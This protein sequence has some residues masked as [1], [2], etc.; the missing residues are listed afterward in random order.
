MMSFLARLWPPYFK[1]N[2]VFRLPARS[3]STRSW[4]TL[5]VHIQSSLTCLT[6]LLGGVLIIGNSGKNWILNTQVLLL[7]LLVNLCTKSS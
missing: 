4:R 2:I 5:L 3:A 7:H 6:R 1:L